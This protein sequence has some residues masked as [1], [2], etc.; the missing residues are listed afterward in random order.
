MDRGVIRQCQNFRRDYADGEAM[1]QQ[2]LRLLAS[3]TYLTANNQKKLDSIAKKTHKPVKQSSPSKKYELAYEIFPGCRG[4]T[5]PCV[6]HKMKRLR[7][8]WDAKLGQWIQQPK[9]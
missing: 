2:Y 3:P 6:S 8:Q 4:M 9:A 1:V 7:Y 5:K